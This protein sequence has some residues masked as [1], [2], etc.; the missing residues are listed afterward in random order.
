LNPKYGS[1]ELNYIAGD[2]GLN[3]LFLEDDLINCIENDE[4]K[5]IEHI[6]V[7]N[8]KKEVLSKK[9][10]DYKDFITKQAANDFSLNINEYDTGIIIYT[11]GT[12]GKPKGVVLTHGNLINATYLPAEFVMEQIDEGVIPD[13]VFFPPEGPMKFLISTPICH[14]TGFMPVLTQISMHNEIVFPLKTSFD[15]EDYCRTIQNEKITAI[16]GVPTMYR[17][18]IDYIIEN[19]DN[20]DLSSVTFITSGGAKLTKEMKTQLLEN[21]PQATLLD[22][23]GSTETLGTSTIAL[24]TSKDIPKIKE[25]HVG[26]VV[27]GV[28]IKIVNENGENLN[29]GEIGEV[30]FKSTTNMRG[31]FGDDLKTR[32]VKDENG[33]LKTG[34]YGRLDEDGNLYFLGRISEIINTG[35]EK[36]YPEELEEFLIAHPKIKIAAVTGIKDKTWGE[37]VGA[38]IQLNPGEKMSKNELNSYCEGNIASFKKPRRIFFVDQ[39]PFTKNEKIDRVEIKRIAENFSSKNL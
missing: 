20:W 24:M 39:I 16:V 1:V 37:L 31:Y 14:L 38:L 5:R 18:L 29:P 11:G 36:V 35:A 21:F 6:F 13:D 27:T 22:G 8:L 4:I 34:D 15:P 32:K 2:V 28:E 10:I 33:W 23:Y 3:G 19:K 25:G 9:I 30:E 7:I 26:Q 12:T 17:L